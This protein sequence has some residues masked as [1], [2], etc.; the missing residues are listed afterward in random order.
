MTSNPT[1]DT[2]ALHNSTKP[3]RKPD[4][5]SASQRHPNQR[6]TRDYGAAALADLSDIK[7]E[8]E[9]LS[10]VVA[11]IT[12]AR[13]R[14]T[15]TVVDDGLNG[16][17]GAVRQNPWAS[18]G[19]AGIAGIVIA[20]A[21]TPRSVEA[22]RLDRLRR[23]ALR[24]I[25]RFDARSLMPDVRDL[26]GYVPDLVAPRL[27]F[28]DRVEKLGN[29]IADLDPKTATAPFIEAARGIWDTIGR[30]KS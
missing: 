1:R 9:R 8:I 2:V 11:E 10:N 24:S 15:V 21:T 17:R 12:S 25:D 3:D 22:N 29:A 26:R 28:A 7:S 18:L 14:Q 30:T 6:A 19:I 27:S 13:A 20:I 5:A 16:V 23:S 4:R